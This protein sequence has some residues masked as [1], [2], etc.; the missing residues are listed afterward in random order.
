MTSPTTTPT[1]SN[2]TSN[3]TEQTGKPK[4]P[5][6]IY[7]LG[8]PGVGKGTLCPLLVKNYTNITYFSVG[9]HL[10]KLLQIPESEANAQTFGGLTY[11]DF[12]GMMKKRESLKAENI[13]PIIHKALKDLTNNTTTATT[14]SDLD[15]D[16]AAPTVFI[17]GFPRSQE[18]AQSADETWGP[19]AVV[20]LFE[21]PRQT[22]QERFLGRKRSSD[23]DVGVFKFRCEGFDRTNPG[24]VELY[25]RVVIPIETGGELEETWELLTDTVGGKLAE[26][27]AMERM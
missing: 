7:I 11:E 22:A 16:L 21:C 2:S 10:R 26:L 8:V 9:D 13:T 23:D 20:F 6:I 1:M 15:L 17:D 18:S 3:P 12:H 5:S 25:S 19:P 4:T 24:T 27:G 14:S